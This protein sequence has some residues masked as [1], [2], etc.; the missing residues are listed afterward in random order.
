MTVVEAVELRPRTRV[1][2]W[3]VVLSAAIVALVAIA[4]LFPGLISHQDPNAVDPVQAL[5]GPGGSHLLGTDQLGRDLFARIVHGAR[6]SLAIGLGAT[7]FAVTVGTG[8]GVLAGAGGRRLDEFLMRITDVLLAFPGLLLALVVVAVLGPG[9][10]NATL[11]IGCSLVPGFT[12]LARSQA[13]VVRGADYV[14][15]AVMFGHPRGRI[16]RLHVLPNTLPPLLV[17]ATV[18]IGT[19]VIAGSSLSFIGLGPTAPTAEWGK[20]LSEGR[21][22]LSIA[23]PMAVFPGLAISLTVVAVNVLGRDLRRRFEGRAS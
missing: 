1:P 8:L 5:L 18:N 12:R 23:W 22:F 15:L 20:M 16:L 6:P 17:L 7:L 19:A 13:L 10:T 9:T 14:R 2:R 11:A 3:G 21:D 4:A